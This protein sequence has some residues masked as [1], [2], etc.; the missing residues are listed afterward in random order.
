MNYCRGTFSLALD[1][2]NAPGVT[3]TPPA[4]AAELG[5]M[6]S[7]QFTLAGTPM[8]TVTVTEGALTDGVTLSEDGNL[9]GI[10][11]E[12][13]DYTFSVTA[14]NGVDPDASLT[15]TPI[16]KPADYSGGALGCS[17]SDSLGGLSSGS[18]GSS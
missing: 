14:S 16:V 1:A 7:D 6:Y 13:G 5:V 15:V 11:T 3:E 17:W 8:P 2:Q 9:S 4:P 18:R 12:P 10:P